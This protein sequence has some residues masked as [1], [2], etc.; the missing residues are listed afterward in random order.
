MYRNLF[1]F[2]TTKNR[3]RPVFTHTTLPQISLNLLSYLAV[4]IAVACLLPASGLEMNHDLV[5]T[6]V[7]MLYHYIYVNFEEEILFFQLYVANLVQK[8]RTQ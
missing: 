7:L 3:R 1:C 6:Q 2:P 8:R 5:Y 4:L